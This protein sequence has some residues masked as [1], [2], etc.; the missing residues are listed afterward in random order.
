M[1]GAVFLS[2]LFQRSIVGREL[3]D[4]PGLLARA[5]AVDATGRGLISCQ[6]GEMKP[7]LATLPQLEGASTALAS[8]TRVLVLT[9]FYIPDAEV[10]AAETDGPLGAVLLS[11]A[12][13]RTGVEVTLLTDEPCL[14]V[15]RTAADALEVVEDR[16]VSAPREIGS[17]WITS[18][19]AEDGGV[20]HVV[21]IE[22]AGPSHTAESL[23]GQSRDGVAPLERFD[24]L[25]N[26]ESRNLVHNMRGRPICESTADLHRIVEVAAEMGICTIGI[27][28]GGN[29]IGMGTIPWESLVDRLGEDPGA[30]IA[31]RVAT[32]WN[33]VAGTSNWGAQAL[34]ISVSQLRGAVD[35][36][37]EWPPERQLELL[38][39]TVDQGPSV[40]GVTGRREATVDGLDFEQF[41]GPWKQMIDAVSS[42]QP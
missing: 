4:L 35:W 20:S 15:L 26:Q 31:C 2:R 5:V 32:D 33:V 11:D 17:D 16:V 24:R 30:R 41:I 18:L 34:A 13:A 27:G 23:A 12:L 6:D 21:A 22:R 29:E 1:K 14:Q 7:C 10:P 39:R 42:G 8:A 25:V 40:D 28:D 9:G 37:K 38:Q 36:W 3:S 19:L